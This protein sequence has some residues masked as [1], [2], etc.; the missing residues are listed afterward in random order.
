MAQIALPYGFAYSH[1]LHLLG[2]KQIFSIQILLYLRF[3]IN[4]G[5]LREETAVKK[6]GLLI[7]VELPCFVCPL[8]L[9]C[10]VEM[11]FSFQTSQMTEQQC[12]AE[13]LLYPFTKQSVRLKQTKPNFCSSYHPQYSQSSLIQVISYLGGK[14]ARNRWLQKNHLQMNIGVSGHKTTK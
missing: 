2:N 8:I 11:L 12:L 6:I 3:L 13:W 1:S 7:V 14:E 5:N 10:M 9:T 4:R